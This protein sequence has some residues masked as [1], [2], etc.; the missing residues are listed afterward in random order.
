MY[1][2]YYYRWRV[3]PEHLRGGTEGT[4]YPGVGPWGFRSSDVERKSDRKTI[5]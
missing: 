3:K 4:S 1:Y 2:T 5:F